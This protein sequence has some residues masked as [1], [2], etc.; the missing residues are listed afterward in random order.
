MHICISIFILVSEH[1]SW[2]LIKAFF[3]IK[4]LFGVQRSKEIPYTP[5]NYLYFS[6]VKTYIFFNSNEYISFDIKLIAFWI[7]LPIILTARLIILWLVNQ[8]TSY[9]S[10]LLLHLGMDDQSFTWEY[11]HYWWSLYVSIMQ[12]FD[13]GQ[14]FHHLP[15]IKL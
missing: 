3:T 7:I 11:F 9:I 15:D 14:G 4:V 8:M 13:S 1:L 10:Q 5:K 2:M 12:H 6:C